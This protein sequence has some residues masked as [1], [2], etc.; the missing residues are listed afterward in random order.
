MN[1]SSLLSSI[2][3]TLRDSL[4][5]EFQ[6]LM[7]AYSEGRW[8]LAGLDAGR[9]CEVVYTILEG[10]ISGSFPAQTKKP[11]N[12]PEACRA[13]ESKAPVP[14]GDRSLRIL[15]PRILPGMYEVRNNRNIGHVGGDVVSNKMDAS[16]LRNNAVWVMSELVRIF[17][18]ASTHEAQSIVDGLSDFPTPLIWEF[19]GTRRVLMP[20][21][22][23]PDKTILLLHSVVGWCPLTDLENWVKADKNF[24][25]NVIRRLAEK[26]LIEYDNINSKVSITPLGI[27]RA[28]QIISKN[29]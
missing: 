14:I 13:L 15:I 20:T 19:D 26:V 22:S 5:E 10:A 1:Q 3:K 9:F 7:R 18:Q 8:K 6:G 2:P 12:F 24:R 29:K 28:E 25:S 4:L 16:Y 23:M 21:L 17:H 11:S 27:Q